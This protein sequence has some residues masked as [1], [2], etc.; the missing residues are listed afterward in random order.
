MPC[1]APKTSPGGGGPSLQAVACRT[2]AA[3]ASSA[4]RT[5]WGVHGS[6]A[7]SSPDSSSA[8]QPAALGLL[9]LVPFMSWC[10]CSV[11]VGTHVTAPPG[12]HTDTPNEPSAHGPR[13]LHV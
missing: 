8:T 12:A 2:G 7:A 1:P 5:P 4:R 3:V 6:P 11:H 9:M 13:E 10:S